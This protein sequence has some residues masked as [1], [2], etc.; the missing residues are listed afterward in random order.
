MIATGCTWSRW[1]GSLSSCSVSGP[2]GAAGRE[3]T[4]LFEV[5]ACGGVDGLR[6]KQRRVNAP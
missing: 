6:R 1:A 3:L 2:P 4:V 5:C